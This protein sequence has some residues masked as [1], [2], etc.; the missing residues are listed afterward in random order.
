MYSTDCPHAMD[1]FFFFKVQMVDPIVQNEFSYEYLDEDQILY[2]LEFFY[3]FL[4][5]VR[6]SLD[7]VIM[8][9]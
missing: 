8:T 4:R 3:Y 2:F 9:L 1:Q 6:K 7:L 5:I